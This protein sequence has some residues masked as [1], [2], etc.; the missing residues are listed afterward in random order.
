MRNADA[1]LALLL[2]GILLAAAWLL[3]SAV[4]PL[5]AAAA[6]VFTIAGFALAV[7]GVLAAEAGWS[8]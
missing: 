1:V 3:G 2:G 4:Y 8:A 7:V 5:V 6:L